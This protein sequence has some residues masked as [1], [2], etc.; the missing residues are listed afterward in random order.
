M[1]RRLISCIVLLLSVCFILTSCDID[2]LTKD[3]DSSSSSSS[4]STTVNKTTT[5]KA[6]KN[7]KKNKKTTTAPTEK[8]TTKPVKKKAKRKQLSIPFHFHL[9]LHILAHHIQK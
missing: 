4:E 3:L 7:T 8:A 6:N 2:E 1:K 9:F 5:T